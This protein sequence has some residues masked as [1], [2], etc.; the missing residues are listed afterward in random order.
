[1]REE[2][3]L[4][5]DDRTPD[6]GGEISRRDAVEK[7]GKAA[8]AGVVAAVGLAGLARVA[9]AEARKTR[10]GMLVDLKRCIGCNA[11]SIACKA[12]NDVPLGTFRRRVRPIITGKFPNV[13]K[14]FVPISC[15]HCEKPECLPKCT[16]KAISQKSDGFVLVDQDKCQKKK[17]CTVACPYRNISTN[18]AKQ[19]AEKCTFCEHR[20]SSGLTP[21][22]VQTC[23]GGA[24][25]FG[26]LNDPSSEIAKAIKAGKARQLKPEA[27]TNPSFY[28]AGLEP[29][30]EQAL[31]KLL[32]KKG[33]ITP[34][35]LEND[36]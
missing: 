22:C 17:G 14:T 8:V 35:E 2:M 21:A 16:V 13:K 5:T 20:V 3:V 19:K 30:V 12:E 7:I 10:W 25:K 28:Y 4:D 33:E 31:N 6:D 32:S 29:E 15:F 27:G 34:R 11:C 23:T 1:M 26:D 18:T 9:S 24:L 36:L